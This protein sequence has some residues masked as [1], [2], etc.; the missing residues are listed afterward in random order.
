MKGER[1][2]VLT[3]Y[4]YY[5]ARFLDRAGVDALLVGDSVNM[6]YHGEATTLSV[7][8]PT[9]LAH[10]RA[11]ARAAEHALVIGD[12]PFLS[13]QPST[14]DAIRNAGRFLKEAGAQAVKLEGGTERAETIRRTIEAGIPVMGHIGLTPQ[15]IHRFG[16]YQVRG[17]NEEQANYL[18][19][20]AQA[21]EEA[22]VFGMVVEAVPTLLAR[23]I[24]ELVNVPTIGI[25]A[26]PHT[27]GQVMVINDIAG[28]FDD[29]KPKFVRRYGDLGAELTRIATEFIRD[30]RKG[31]FPGPDESY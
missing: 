20:S 26:G 9:M 1:V 10:T 29:F 24:T 6:V 11:V 2:A 12:M 18:K 14:R 15:S 22:G 17:K 31:D 25:G 28:L 21:L 7:D 23:E 16:G 27:D 19:E 5:T 30:V 8:M 13:Y 4:D 3:A